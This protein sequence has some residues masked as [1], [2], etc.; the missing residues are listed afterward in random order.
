[1]CLGTFSLNRH[2][3]YTTTKTHC[4]M[5]TEVQQCYEMHLTTAFVNTVVQQ[6]DLFH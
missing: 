2:K 4:D 3:V 5:I 6:K 1:M